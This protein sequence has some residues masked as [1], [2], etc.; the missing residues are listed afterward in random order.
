MEHKKSKYFLG[1]DLGTNSVGWC[2]TDENYN[3]VKRNGKAL[4][5]AALFSEAE[6]AKASR[7]QRH[8]K[9]AVANTK[10]RIHLLQD[11]LTPEIAK[12]DPNFF[13]RLELSKYHLEDREGFFKEKQILF[14]DP[15][16]NDRDYYKRYPTI[17]HL[18]KDLLY[19]KEKFDIRLIYLALHHSIKYRG[20]FLKEGE[21]F[22]PNA[23]DD[24]EA[25][26]E[27]LN[28]NLNNLL[29]SM[30]LEIEAGKKLFKDNMSIST[31]EIKNC[32]NP[33]ELSQLLS[34]K[35]SKSFID[36]VNKKSFD[37]DTLLHFIAGKNADLNKLFGRHDSDEEL[38][39]VNLRSPD[40]DEKFEQI[41][42]TLTDLEVEIFVSCKKIS[43]AIT[44]QKIL[45]DNATVC[46][47]M[48]QKY[49]RHRVDLRELKE[50]LKGDPFRYKLVFTYRPNDLVKVLNSSQACRTL[51]KELKIIDDDKKVFQEKDFK[52]LSN[53]PAYI[54]FNYKCKK[55]NF[56]HAGKDDFY[57]F[58]KKVLKISDGK[59]S[60]Q[61]LAD[62][63][64]KID[65]GEYLSRLKEV[66]NS[67]FPYQLTLEEVKRILA[68]QSKYY[69]I[70]QA[71]YTEG[72]AAQDK[73]EKIISFRKPY[74]IGPTI[75]GGSS[76]TK[77]ERNKF[78]WSVRRIPSTK[79]YPWNFEEVMNY[80]ESAENFIKRMLNKCTYLKDEF[81]LPKNSL[82]FSF[83]AYLNEINKVL[84]NGQNISREDKL[85]LYFDYFLKNKPSGKNLS[86]F[87]K[88]KNAT[89]DE[90]SITTSTGKE[91][92][93]FTFDFKSY[94]DFWQLLKS[95]ELMYKYWD[96]IDEIINNLILFT[97]VKLRRQR[98]E[99]L[100][101]SI[102]ELNNKDTIDRI[103][104]LKYSGY[105]RLSKKLLTQ[106]KTSRHERDGESHEKSILDLMIDTKFNFMEVITYQQYDF[107][108]KIH[109]INGDEVANISNSHEKVIEY[110]N[111]KYVSPGMK[112]ALIQAYRI[113]ADLN[114]AN[115]EISEYY[116]EVGRS[117][118]KSEK[119]IS[120]KQK[121]LKL[122]SKI[123]KIADK[124]VAMDKERLKKELEAKS[125]A[126]L[127]GEKLF[128][129]FT[130]MGK[131]MYS[132]KPITIDQV[133]SGDCDVDHIIPRTL[134]K[135]DSLDNKVLVLQNENKQK[136][137]DYPIPD[138]LLKNDF[139]ARVKFLKESDLISEDKSLR[140]L[141]RH[142]LESQE[143]EGFIKRQLVYT[144]QAENALIDLIKKVL[145]PKAK[146]IYSKAKL[147]SDFR[148]QFN[149][150]KCRELNNLHH[151]HDA[152]LNIV[153]G[154][155]INAHFKEFTAGRLK[156]M[157]SN[158]LTTNT[159]KIFSLN[160][161]IDAAKNTVWDRNL[162]FSTIQKNLSHSKDIRTVV[163]T[164]IK[165]GLINQSTLKPASE[166]SENSLPIK[167]KT[168]KFNIYMDPIKYGSYTSPVYGYFCLIRV[169]NKYQ[170]I[171]MP[172]IY[173][174]H[175]SSN[176]QKLK[177][178][179][180]NIGIKNAELILPELKINTVVFR[181]NSKFCISG[182]DGKNTLHIRNLK[183]AF[184]SFEET[185]KLK[186][187]LSLL[188]KT[189]KQNKVNNKTPKEPTDLL[190][191]EI[192]GLTDADLE[193]LFDDLKMRLSKEIY[194]AFPC[195]RQLGMEINEEG[196]FNTLNSYQK[197]HAIEQLCQM[198]S[199]SSFPILKILKH[200]IHPLCI[201]NTLRPGD[202]ILAE[203]PTG[204]FTKVLFKVQ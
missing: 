155:V 189:K 153:V 158:C 200:S 29:E 190:G 197:A 188:E 160:T 89:C 49:E 12:V 100:V 72:F 31:D 186:I 82:T 52:G 41:S 5:G 68:N 53:Y 73:I 95:K 92:N 174:P 30:S 88:N 148:K 165:H 15:N 62:V 80:E 97:D 6:S 133:F 128:L 93:E 70:F 7:L 198:F 58:L 54:G 74:F 117:H 192:S 107:L 124:E 19:K 32:K 146:V 199:A 123:K 13:Q 64:Q 96:Q 183:E 36:S 141:R 150:P 79:I 167:L 43:D 1:L 164:F 17:Y 122:Y 102:P 21:D 144:S 177:Y 42:K 86:K 202:T 106:V 180:E 63:S 59:S 65:S 8:S 119:T 78:A 16:F 48:V 138:S 204:L 111:Q 163:S 46:E 152:Y 151:A 196:G 171:A 184:Y 159:D 109:Q 34:D 22:K 114:K 33:T 147:V 60:E 113:I 56:S 47:A 90:I 84:V 135:D 85:E 115:I 187:L 28:E 120:R 71:K 3:I 129:Y 103:C 169:K 24:L 50:Y 157:R 178:I 182:K 203:S 44:L 121:V 173:V 130:Q 2:V 25:A 18:K 83:Y 39:K 191:L 87:F 118:E 27:E 51:A 69:D 4:I 77:T 162:T 67:L 156:E 99:R 175:N 132:G 94:K 195:Y 110:I 201:S 105:G 9:R 26:F 75:G 194:S 104:K 125:E 108:N 140:L 101:E 139:R 112:R 136:G 57:K 137:A 127:R 20:N 134:L 98:T 142:E 179:S 45:G 38:K 116:I 166:S 143:L 81:C 55:E 14:V 154:R 131:S 181:G 168:G 170:I 37:F 66:D 126:E 185:K 61:F 23:A 10:E 35:T 172:N 76:E 176:E 161:I 11:L 149:L 193:S 91:F 40:F 145:D